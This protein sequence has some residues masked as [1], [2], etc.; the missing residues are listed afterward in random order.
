M[1]VTT[2]APGDSAAQRGAE[3]L[4]VEELTKQSGIRLTKKR[5]ALPDGGRPEIDGFSESPQILCEAWAHIGPA[6]SAQKNKLLTDAFKLLYVSEF[7]PKARRSLALVDHDAGSPLKG[8]RM[9]CPSTEKVR[10][11]G[12]CRSPA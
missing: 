5:L 1:K 9:V 2:L 12:I 3:T 4:I 10:N 7:Y 6:K 11:R 8:N